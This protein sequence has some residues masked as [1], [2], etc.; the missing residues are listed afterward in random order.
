M[1]HLCF[2]SCF[3]KY[4]PSLWKICNVTYMWHWAFII[5]FSCYIY[6]A[7]ISQ[8]K[9]IHF[10]FFLLNN[11]FFFCLFAFPQHISKLLLF[12]EDKTKT[13]FRSNTVFIFYL[14]C[15]NI[16]QN[17]ITVTIKF[18]NN[19]FVTYQNSTFSGIWF[20]QKVIFR[21]FFSQLENMPLVTKTSVL[22]IADIAT[23]ANQTDHHFGNVAMATK[24]AHIV[25]WLNLSVH[26]MSLRDFLSWKWGIMH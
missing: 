1:D 20:N 5:H 6:W 16:F 10:I 26:Y 23:C 12:W 17:H 9:K 14:L 22:K 8:L 21:F 15:H 4:N 11:S 24:N 19:S 2:C 7:F 3:F 25:T 13:F 18:Y